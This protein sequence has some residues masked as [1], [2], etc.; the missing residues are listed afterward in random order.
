[1]EFKITKLRDVYYVNIVHITV[2]I[3]IHIN[4]EYT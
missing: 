1:M 4:R 3:Y 2:N